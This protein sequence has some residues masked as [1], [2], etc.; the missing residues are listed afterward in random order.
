MIS[1]S[2]LAKAPAICRDFQT[3]RPFKHACVDDFLIPDIAERAL[4]D[5]PAFDKA[6]AINEYGEV[7][8]KAVNTK[9][10]DIS[11]FYAEF[12]DWLFS[13]KFLGAM[14]ELTGIPDL[15]G[16]PTLYGGGTHENLHGQELDPHVD[17]NYVSGGKAHRRVNL[18]IYLNKGWNSAWGGDIEVHSNPRDPDRNEIKSYSVGFNRAVFFETN[19]YS[20]H[21]FP[22]INL[23]PDIRQK[24]SRKCL[25]I[26]LYTNTRPAEEIVGT[27]GTFYVQRP[28]GKQ[29]IP[30]YVLNSE[31][32]GELKGGLIKRD[33]SIEF[34]Q[35]LDERMGR[36]RDGLHRYL[37]EIIARVRLPT[38]GNAIQTRRIAGRYWHDGWIGDSLECEFQALD[39]ITA[40]ELEGAIPFIDHF[41]D[42][43]VALAINNKSTMSQKVTTNRVAISVRA[44]VASGSKFTLTITA[45]KSAKPQDIGRGGDDRSLSFIV[46]LLRFR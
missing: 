32:V 2:V 11:P 10:A 42:L 13:K 24:N 27:H 40:L 14:S 33:R 38:A 23:P 6:K 44:D 30:G 39:K 43:E 15:I 9:L 25:S 28:L 34:Y 8:G 12:Y 16:D 1:K 4:A 41:G 3:A 36:E 35:K 31:D 45:S 29:F 7:G 46:T 18:L 22:R 21:G 20:W 37:D 17:F 5:F 19:E 26:Y